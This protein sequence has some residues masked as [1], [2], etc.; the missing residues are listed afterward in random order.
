[1]KEK[2]PKNEGLEDYIHLFKLQLSL[3]KMDGKMPLLQSM[4]HHG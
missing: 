2:E 4:E 1:M 3:A